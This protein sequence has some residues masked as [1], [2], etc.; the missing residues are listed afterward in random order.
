MIPAL[1]VPDAVVALVALVAGAV[2]AVTGFGI[3][4]FL[5]MGTGVSIRGRG[6]FQILRACEQIVE[7][8][9][10]RSGRRG[11]PAG[12]AHPTTAGD[13]PSKMIVHCVASDAAHRSSADIIRKCVRN[14]LAIAEATG[15]ESIAMPLFATGHARFN[16]DQAVLAMAETLRD[17]PTA[18]QHVFIVVYDPDRAEEAVR[19]IRSVIPAADIDMQR[20]PHVTEEPL[21]MWSARV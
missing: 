1:Q 4:S 5:I 3:G 12:S 13:L 21:D 7:A 16:F 15:C 18:V 14:S 20:G 8:E 11:L 19:L 2:A 6:G 17:Q 9:F 10:R